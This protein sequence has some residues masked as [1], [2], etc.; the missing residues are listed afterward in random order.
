[1]VKRDSDVKRKSTQIG[2]AEKE[3]ERPKDAVSR[4]VQSPMFTGISASLLL[5][6]SAFIGVQVEFGFSDQVPVEVEAVD[7]VFCVCFLVELGFRLWGY[8]CHRYWCDSEDWAWNTFD[9][10]IVTTSTFDTVMS[11]VS[12][13]DSALGNISALRVIRVVRIVRVLRII[14]V[15]KFFADLRILLAAIISTVK[16]ASFA[17]VLITFIVYMFAIAITQLVAE[18]VKEQRANN[19]TPEHE[20]DLM[21]FLEVFSHQSSHYT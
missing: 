11:A 12:K 8:G 10:V 9:F 6:N 21:Y 19:Q 16:T 17:F 1:M 18:F 7:M 5:A 13:A 4:F 15:M 3:K 20:E 2:E 14:R